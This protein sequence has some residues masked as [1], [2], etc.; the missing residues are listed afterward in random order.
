M[1][2]YDGYKEE[3]YLNDFKPDKDFRK[4]INVS[5]NEI[6]ILFR[7]PA[8]VGNYHNK[9]SEELIVK[10]I[11]HCSSFNHTI[12]LISYRTEYDKAYLIDKLKNKNNIKFLE[13][14]VDGLQL[15]YTSDIFIGAGGTMNRESALL[16][17]KTYSIFSA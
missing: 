1:S 2:R 3:L 14:A 11:N 13:E 6:L 17:T 9:N 7:T 8:M 12:C 15:V 5:D 4:N 10:L 16:G